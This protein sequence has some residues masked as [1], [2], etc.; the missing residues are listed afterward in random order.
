MIYKQYTGNEVYFIT[1]SSLV[2]NLMVYSDASIIFLERHTLANT[3][4]L[5]HTV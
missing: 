2:D 1:R 4:I 3:H 5:T